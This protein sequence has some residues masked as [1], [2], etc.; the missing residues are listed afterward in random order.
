M[1]PP[2]EQS[3]VVYNYGEIKRA[4]RW[5][6][7]VVIAG[8]VL[9]IG[10]IVA[11][12]IAVI[13]ALPDV[14]ESSN[15]LFGPSPLETGPPQSPIAAEPLEC[16][17][18]CFT[19]DVIAG[20]I[21]PQ[22]RLDELG[23]TTV[24]NEWGDYAPTDSAWEYSYL[25]SEWQ[26]LGSEADS[27]FFTLPQFA[28]ATELGHAPAEGDYVDFTGTS[29][30]EDEFG[31][32]TQSVRIFP[33]SREAVAHMWTLNELIP[34]C[35]YYSYDLAVE[36]WSGTLSPAPALDVPDTVAAIGWRE[37]NSIG[38]YYVFDLQYANIVVR[39]A[40]ASPDVVSEAQYRELVVELA[41]HLA[42]L[43]LPQGAA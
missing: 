21:V 18:Q 38:R 2:P 34:R 30:S 33:T 13:N 28:L 23:F 15:G 37:A 10:G 19:D 9:V 16:A 27:C 1:P 6:P 43:E 24:T 14:I 4:P 22:A 36:D 5:V 25:E 31:Y 39:T 20:T 41:E 12:G 35:T 29:T 40:M 26:R 17:N 3:P 8:V 11:G 42:Q 7:P 32:F